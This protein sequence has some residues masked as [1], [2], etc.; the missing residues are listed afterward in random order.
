MH[1]VGITGQNGFIGNHLYNR[2]SLLNDRY[3]LVYFEKSFFSDKKSLQAFV[4][5]CDIIV[6]L[7]GINRAENQEEVYKENMLITDCLINAIKESKSTAHIIFSSSIQET[8]NNAYGISKKESSLKLMNFTKL[9]N[10]K[11]TSLIIPNVYGPFCKPF[12][13]SV[14][15]TFCHQVINDENPIIKIDSKLKLIFVDDLVEL[16]IKCFNQKEKMKIIKIPYSISVKVSDVLKHINSFKSKYVKN[17][18][19]PDLKKSFIKNLFNTFRSHLNYNDIYPF[20]LKI[21]SDERGSFVETMKLS[22][23]GQVSFSLTHP[24]VTRGNHFHTRKTERFAVIKGKA[25][26]EFRKI[27]TEKKYVFQLDGSKPSFVDMPVW[28]THNITNVGTTDLYTIFWVD[29]IFNKFDPDTYF[30][31]V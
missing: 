13:N 7:A 28:Y 25:K 5:K 16:I 30:M 21:N 1:N 9:N 8:L 14:V 23:R 3:S 19:I 22:S 10:L 31:E 15:A 11:F 24:N 4:K 17:G 6:H 27:G 12:Y 18:I 29:E 2:L 20:K 26:I